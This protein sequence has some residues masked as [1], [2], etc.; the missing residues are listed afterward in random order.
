VKEE[1]ARE[2]RKSKRT[3]QAVALWLRL[4]RLVGT[5]HGVLGARLRSCRISLAQ[6]DVIAQV[7]STEGVT[8]RELAE[9]MVVTE[10]NI[11]QLLQKME[12]RSWVKRE[13]IGR[14][15][16]VALTE[17][18]RRL[19]DQLVP[20]Q[21]RAIGALFAPLSDS[22]LETLSRLLRRIQRRIS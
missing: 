6:F 22:E 10:G 17:Q 21:E 18:G 3:R 13:Q 16:R 2:G 15:N 4:A 7:G 20:G 11:T 14:C 12:M 5:Q 1:Q 19:R 8:Q 9:R